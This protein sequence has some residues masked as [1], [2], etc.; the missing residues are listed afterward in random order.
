VTSLPLVIVV[1]AT[2]VLAA[3]A[4]VDLLLRR[5]GSA[6]ARHLVWTIAIVGLLALPLA[7]LSLPAWTL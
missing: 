7:S 5:R 1:K 4:L 6:A 3:A 2:A